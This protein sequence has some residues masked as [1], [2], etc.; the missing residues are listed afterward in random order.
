MAASVV[1]EFDNDSLQIEHFSNSYMKTTVKMRNFY[2]SPIYSNINKSI[3]MHKA[4]IYEHRVLI[5]E[6]LFS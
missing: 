1:G 6:I 2:I 5:A 3:T 4:D